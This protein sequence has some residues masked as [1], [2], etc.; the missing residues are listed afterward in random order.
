[1]YNIIPL[2]E[3]LWTILRPSNIGYSIFYLCD[4]SNFDKMIN[5]CIT[6]GSLRVFPVI[7]LKSDITL[8]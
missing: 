2:H 4:N 5:Y 7:Y 6:S 8:S 3:L 1:M